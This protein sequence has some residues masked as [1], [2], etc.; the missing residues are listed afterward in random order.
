M[1]KRSGWDV[2]EYED[3]GDGKVILSTSHCT[4]KPMVSATP[5]QKEYDCSNQLHPYP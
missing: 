3:G 5:S 2:N 4:P 1:K